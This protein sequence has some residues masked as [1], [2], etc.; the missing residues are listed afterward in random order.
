M[1][2]LQKLILPALFILVIVVI[3]LL[4]FAPKNELG[5]FT[6]FDPNNNAV[7]E[8]RVL[9]VPENGINQDGHGGATFFVKDKNNATLQ[10]SAEKVPTGIESAKTLILKGHLSGTTAFHAH[11]VEIN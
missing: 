9:L 1:K 7:K 4:Y 10:V 3:Y 8:I 2:Y 5:S 6:D 11:E